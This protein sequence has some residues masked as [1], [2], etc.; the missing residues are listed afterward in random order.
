MISKCLKSLLFIDLQKPKQSMKQGKGGTP[1]LTKLGR[2]WSS[3][4]S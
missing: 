1:I 2:P 3:R 4:K